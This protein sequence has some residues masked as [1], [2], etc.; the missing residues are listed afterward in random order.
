MTGGRVLGH[1]ALGHGPVNRGHSS[2]VGGLGGCLVALFDGA[3]HVLDGGAYVRALAGIAAAVF[4]RLTR[5][6]AS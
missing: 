6:L 2:L 3:Q 4:F 1:Q 5:P